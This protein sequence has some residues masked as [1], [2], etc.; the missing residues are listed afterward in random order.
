M[1]KKSRGQ[2]KVCIQRLKISS[3]MIIYIERIHD[4]S[5]RAWAAAGVAFAAPILS[6]GTACCTN[7]NQEDKI[8]R[9]CLKNTQNL[10]AKPGVHKVAPFFQNCS[11]TVKLRS[12][13]PSKL[14]FATLIKIRWLYL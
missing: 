2:K 12:L 5:K 9:K 1:S 7:K 10:C 3:A 4:R 6:V 13:A 8:L 14:N 11:G